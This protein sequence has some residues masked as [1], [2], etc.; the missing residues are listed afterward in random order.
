MMYAALSSLSGIPIDQR[1]AVTG[2]ANPFGNV[3]V[4]GGAE[5]QDGGL[6][7]GGEQPR[8]RGAR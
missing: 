7:Q 2:S 5:P 1:F 8:Q 4:I 6:L 3:Q